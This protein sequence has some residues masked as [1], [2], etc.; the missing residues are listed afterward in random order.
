LLKK[1]FQKIKHKLIESIF[2]S[3]FS[4]YLSPLIEI[5]VSLR[6]LNV[7]E[8]VYNCWEDAPQDSNILEDKIWVDKVTNQALKN[9]SAFKSGKN[10]PLA[11]STQDYILSLA[12]GILLS[13]NKDNL[14]ILDFGGGMGTSYFP[15]ISSL[16]DP[17]KLEF[18]IVELKTICDL[19]QKFLGDF[20]QLHF[21]ESLPNLSK[22]PHIIHA[23]S[24]I[25]YVSD[26][27]KLLTEFANY[28]PNILILEDILA[29]D[30][31]GFV[32]TQNF[33]GKRI[34]SRFLNINELIEELQSLDYQLIYKSHC[35]QNFLGKLGGPLPM[36]NFPPQYRLEYCSHLIFKRMKS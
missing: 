20:S 2:T 29:G 25:Q 33:Y 24:S 3:K 23:G 10:F 18:H 17:K 22:Q 1:S 26:W 6:I 16:P 7:W 14:C 36:K 27:K 34:R 28:R 30:I 5:L 12:G 32:T 31:P 13:Y 11:S 8:G 9:I 15:L 35:K 19:A 4:S 21:Y